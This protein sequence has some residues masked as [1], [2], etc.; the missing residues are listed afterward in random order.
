[1]RNFL[2]HKPLGMANEFNYVTTGSY[3]TISTKNIKSF[4]VNDKLYL[5]KL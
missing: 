3:Q 5:S 1:M 2:L 4:T